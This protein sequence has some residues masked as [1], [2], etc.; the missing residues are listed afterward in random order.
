M[1]L[2]SHKDILLLIALELNLKDLFNFCQTCKIINEK[3]YKN[4]TFWFN[5]LEKDYGIKNI[6]P[7]ETY[8]KIDNLLRKTPNEAYKIGI[9]NESLILIK[10]SLKKGAYVNFKA[11]DDKYYPLL[12]IIFNDE[13]FDYLLDKVFISKHKVLCIIESFP[14]FFND[15]D[16]NFKK[17]E[18]CKLIKKLYDKMFPLSLKFL[19]SS[20]YK[21]Y[22]KIILSKF[23]EAYK[24]YEYPDF[25][26]FYHKWI[27]FYR[28]LSK[29]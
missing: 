22:W 7:K 26:E 3:I 9:D 16:N 23:E 29:D 14:M 10:L 24:V 21:R 13:I 17:R 19:L 18:K 15:T 1:N 20:Q 6:N 5:K 11:L 8:L 2:F 28:D 27:D 12:R 25:R 4:K